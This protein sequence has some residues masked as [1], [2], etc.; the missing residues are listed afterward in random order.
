MNLQFPNL[1]FAAGYSLIEVLLAMAVLA[2]GA[3][4]TSL[5]LLSSV[6]GTVRAEERSLVTLQASELAQ[7]IHANPAV[8]GHLIQG[9]QAVTECSQDQACTQSD[10]A[11][12]HLQQWQLDLQQSISAAQGIIC[13]D[14]SPQDGNLEDLSCDG[15]GDAVVKVVWQETSNSPAQAGPHRLALPLPQ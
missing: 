8:W 12:Q 1:R 14:S 2:I 3:A 15:E 5:L 6:Q 7:L 13:R 9:G 4:G 11:S 10:W